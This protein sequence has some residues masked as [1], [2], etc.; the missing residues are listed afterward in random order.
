MQKLN[1]D[2]NFLL[3]CVKMQPLHNILNEHHSLG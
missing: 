1:L 3:F 2:S